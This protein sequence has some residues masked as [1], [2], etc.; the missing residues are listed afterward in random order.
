MDQYKA[1]LSI[2]KVAL[3]S[4]VEGELD[5]IQGDM[6]TALQQ[7]KDLV[8]RME[9]YLN[10]NESKVKNFLE[11]HNYDVTVASKPKKI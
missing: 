5:R 1:A 3:H 6:A 2:D 10:E 11:D 4:L 8:G 9:G 7:A